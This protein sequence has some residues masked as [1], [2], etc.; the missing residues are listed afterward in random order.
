M[1]LPNLLTTFDE[2]LPE[3]SNKST[4]KP[5]QTQESSLRVKNEKPPRILLSNDGKKY[6][7]ATE[8]YLRA[9]ADLLAHEPASPPEPNRVV[10]NEADVVAHARTNLLNPIMRAINLETSLEG[11]VL[12][13]AELGVETLRV[14]VGIFYE[15]KSGEGIVMMVEFK[16]ANLIDSSAFRVAM[17]DKQEVDKYTKS[18]R[19]DP[20]KT[21]EQDSMKLVK[22]AKAYAVRAKCLY[23]ALCD[24]ES[25]VLLK[26]SE[27][28]T[29]IDVTIVDK[30]ETTFRRA[31]FGFLLTAVEDY[32][33]VPSV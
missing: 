26:F 7:D 9:H 24:Y 6:M 23:V 18:I 20:S 21:L 14:D 10:R 27:D 8:E 29:I 17:W 13:S 5:K 32:D 19:E 16:R 28:T 22:Q 33:S 2:G 25:L 11:K 15:F 1:N 4:R 3:I 12:T 31:L 30:T